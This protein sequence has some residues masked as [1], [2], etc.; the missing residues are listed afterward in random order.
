ML[1]RQKRRDP[2]EPDAGLY[3]TREGTVTGRKFKIGQL[4]N[5]FGRTVFGELSRSDGIKRTSDMTP[6]QV[7]HKTTAPYEQKA[8]SMKTTSQCFTSR[9]RGSSFTS[10]V[11]EHS[12]AFGST[13]PSP[14]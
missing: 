9:G 8:T 4:V 1:R 10:C 6:Q 7:A 13:T 12:S 5:Y 14:A 3:D 11:I 2:A